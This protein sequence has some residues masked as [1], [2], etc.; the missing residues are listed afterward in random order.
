MPAPPDGKRLRRLRALVPTSLG[1][2]R[3]PS[4]NSTLLAQRGDILAIARAEIIEHAHAIAALDQRA[5]NMRT[6]ETRAAGNQVS[7]H[8]GTSIHRRA[9]QPLRRR[10][11]KLRYSSRRTGGCAAQPRI[12][13]LDDEQGRRRLRR[14]SH[15][16]REPNLDAT[17]V[18]RAS[19][20]S[21]ARS[22][23]QAGRSHR[24]FEC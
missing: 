24:F 1:L 14:R 7:A 11:N 17:R 15:R 3:S 2:T 20:A 8:R 9:A 18:G 4:M 19:S 16:G 6:D 5:R 22:A 10:E 21:A 23:A 13:L 12:I